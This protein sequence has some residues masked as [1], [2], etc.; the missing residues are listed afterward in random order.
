MAYSKVIFN[1]ST[2]MDVTDK[3]VTAET[4]LQG[5]TA[6]KNDGTSITG[7]YVGGGG[8]GGG[9]TT[10]SVYNFTGNIYYVDSADGTLKYVNTGVWTGSVPSGSMVVLHW[11]GPKPPSGSTL[12][13]LT[14]VYSVSN[15]SRAQYPVTDFCIA[16]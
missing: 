7:T 5:E 3:T 15:G 14:I 4:L 10:V 8:G 2:L 16:D 1:G 9:S 12:T 13:N 6:L 11:N